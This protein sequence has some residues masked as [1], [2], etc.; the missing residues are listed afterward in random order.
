MTLVLNGTTGVSGA[1]GSAATPAIQGADTNTGIFF[2]A[3][4]T[5]AIATNGS[6]RARIDSSGRLLINLTTS[7][8]SQALLQVQQNCLTG[9]LA[10]FN[11]TDTTSSNNVI[12]FRKN[13]TEA[14]KIAVTTSNTTQYVTSSDYRLK[15]NV[16]PMG[17]ALAKVQA[18]KPVTYTWKST[19]EASQGFIAHELAEVC[20]D[21][22]SGEKDAINEDGSI[23]PQGIDT[24]FLVATLTAAIQ[25]QQALIT[26]LTARIAALEQ[27]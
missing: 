15:E 4:D 10:E 22:V 20:P 13:G 12:R 5:V 24:S 2:P 18:L 1:D 7:I 17:S 25:E 9:V 27:A 8:S 23:N 16:Q 3:A 14:G 19:G 6:E 11:D 26:A 21:A